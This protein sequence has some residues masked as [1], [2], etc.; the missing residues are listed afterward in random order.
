MRCLSATTRTVRERTRPSALR[1]TRAFGASLA[2]NC[3]ADAVSRIGPPRTQALVAEPSR[4][5][6][7][8]TPAATRS[9]SVAVDQCSR[10]TRR[11]A[12][13]QPRHVLP[14]NCNSLFRAHVVDGVRG[15]G[16]L[17][18]RTGRASPP[19]GAHPR[20]LGV[21]RSSLASR[22][23]EIGR[24]TILVTGRVDPS[25]PGTSVP[26][27]ARDGQRTRSG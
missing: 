23:R 3:R 27:L 19:G 2:K 16:G 6:S 14:R 8:W 5:R 1:R 7:S 15:A 25:L 13:A 10:P 11:G 18:G 21:L 22:W 12:F 9:I 20:A 26:R 24:T 17:V 4:G